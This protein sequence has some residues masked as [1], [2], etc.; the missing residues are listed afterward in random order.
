[1]KSTQ[2]HHSLPAKTHATA[3]LRQHAHTA[4]TL[5]LMHHVYPKA[6]NNIPRLFGNVT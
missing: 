4:G 6:Q 1:M 3:M 5:G 2:Q